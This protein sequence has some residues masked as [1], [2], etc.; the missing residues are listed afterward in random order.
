MPVFE[1]KEKHALR[2][3]SPTYKYSF[4]K[5]KVHTF[6]CVAKEYGKLWDITD[7]SV[8]YYTRKYAGLF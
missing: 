4:C 8:A 2:P 5:E 7:R 6:E 3:N 1:W